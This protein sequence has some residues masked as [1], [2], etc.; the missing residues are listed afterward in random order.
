MVEGNS[1]AFFDFDGTLT[2]KDSM[3]EFLVFHFGKAKVRLA[4]M[5]LA[6]QLVGMKLHFTPAQRV[7]EKLLYYFLKRL[8]HTEVLTMGTDFSKQR[9][10]EILRAVAL[11]KLKWH[12]Q[13][14]HAVYV[15]S[16][17]CEAWLKP[18]CDANDVGLICSRM[19]FENGLFTGRLIGNNVNGPEKVH[20]IKRAVDLNNY[21][22]SYAYGDT[23]GDRNMLALADHAFYRTFD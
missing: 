15:V 17:S 6:P 19:R 7:K 16:A 14:G 8:H 12:Q 4:L 3:L 21:S 13:Q 1:I 23:R 5:R 20:A 22:T 18:W 2:T 11:K 9:M 10:P